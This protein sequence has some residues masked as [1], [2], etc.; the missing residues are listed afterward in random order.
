MAKI[1]LLDG[2]SPLEEVPHNHQRCIRCGVVKNRQAF[3]KAKR[4]SSGLD[5]ACRL[6]RSTRRRE[7][8]HENIEHER[9]IDNARYHRTK[10]RNRAYILMKNYGLTV[11]EYDAIVGRQAGLCAI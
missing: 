5:S 9:A 11:D 2:S 3:M 8:R 10:D 6:C 4:M 1:V 7:H